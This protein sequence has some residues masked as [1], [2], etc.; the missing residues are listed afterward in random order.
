VFLFS[1]EVFTT[2]DHKFFASNPIFEKLNSGTGLS[3]SCP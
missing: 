1:K 2:F 3:K